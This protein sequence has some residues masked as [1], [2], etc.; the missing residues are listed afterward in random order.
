MK[1]FLG[2]VLVLGSLVVPAFAAKNS[3]SLTLTTPVTVGTTQLPAGD[4][5]VTWTGTGSTYKSPS[6]RKAKR[7]STSP[8]SW[9]TQRMATSASSPTPSTAQ[10]SCKPSSLTTRTSYSPAPPR[11]ASKSLHHSVPRA[12]GLPMRSQELELQSKTLMA[13]VAFLL[14]V[15]S[16]GRGL[17][18]AR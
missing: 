3:Q 16:W 1:R 11:R 10:P 13:F 17:F 4:Y 15:P 18:F 6:R 5:K 8:P 9:S 2:Y 7:P 12:N 14:P